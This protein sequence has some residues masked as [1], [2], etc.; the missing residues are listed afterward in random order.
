M[1]KLLDIENSESAERARRIQILRN[2]IE[3]TKAPRK[4][5]YKPVWDRNLLKR[6]PMNNRDLD[7]ALY[8][9]YL[10]ARRGKMRTVD[11]YNFEVFWRENLVHLK[12]DIINRKWKPSRS[13]AFITHTPVDREI[14]AAPFRDRIVHHLLYAVVAPWWDKQFIYDSY[15]C[16]RGKG[17]DF[18][19]VRMQSFM[20]GASLCGKRKAYVL[21]GDLSGYF[22]SLNRETLYRK[23]MWGLDRQFPEKGWLYELCKYLWKEVIFDDPAFGAR[24]V[25]SLKDWDILPRNKSL[26]CQSPGRG[27]VIGNLT[28]QLLSNIMLNEF[29]WWMKRKMRFRY[30]GRYVDDF[31]VVVEEGEYERAKD[32]MKHLAPV[33][34]KEMGLKMHPKKLYIQEVRKGCPFLGKLVKPTVLLPGK[35]YVRNMKKA[36]RG[37]IEGTASYDTMQSYVGMGKN[38]AA[39]KLMMK[40]VDR[41]ERIGD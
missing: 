15:S 36:F 20:R 27:I 6:L 24:R 35:R 3:G 41:I 32:V 33:R 37:Y 28:S 38:M 13:K 18:G 26:F 11:Q 1:K 34:L 22:M 21:K 5:K 7:D 25:G 2:M 8:E 9:C 40:T 39:Y 30:Y 17:T 10:M 14:F 4:K 29:D 31:F 16:R 19:V 23:V 12:E